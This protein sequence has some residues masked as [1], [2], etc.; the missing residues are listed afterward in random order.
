MDKSRGLRVCVCMRLSHCVILRTVYSKALNMHFHR[1]IFYQ[2]LL[3]SSNKVYKEENLMS[4]FVSALCVSVHIGMRSYGVLH[5]CV[6][7]S[8]CLAAG[9]SGMGLS[10]AVV[11]RLSQ[12]YEAC[13]F[14]GQ[15]KL[16]RQGFYWRFELCQ[17]QIEL[18]N[19]FNPSG[20]K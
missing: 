5:V 11:V 16:L 17:N 1:L 2:T 4:M 6:E 3:A 15:A 12:W 18:H 7:T 19:R 14:I 20:H 9:Q 8:P 10:L 13:C